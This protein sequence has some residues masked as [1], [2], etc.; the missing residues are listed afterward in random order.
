MTIKLPSTT[1]G[2]R[3]QKSGT[4]TVVAADVPASVEQ[5]S[6]REVEQARQFYALATSR[7]MLFGDRG[8]GL[9]PEHYLTFDPGFGAERTLNIGHVSSD[10]ELGVEYELLCSED[11]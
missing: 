10:R 11:K 2:D 1:V 6:G 8:W 9:S 7:V 3:G 4:D 5:L